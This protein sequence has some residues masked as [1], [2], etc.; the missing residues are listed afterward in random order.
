MD[1]MMCTYLPLPVH[2]K[3]NFKSRKYYKK[4]ILNSGKRKANWF[5]TRGLEE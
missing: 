1:K 2:T 3:Y 4:I 5:G